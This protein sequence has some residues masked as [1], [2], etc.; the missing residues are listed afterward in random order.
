[1]NN[2]RN[3]LYCFVYTCKGKKWIY[4][5]I[6]AYYI[7]CIYICISVFVPFFE[8]CSYQSIEYQRLRKMYLANVISIKIL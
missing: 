3:V 4:I 5:H 6:C 2:K 1:M 8:R 7:I